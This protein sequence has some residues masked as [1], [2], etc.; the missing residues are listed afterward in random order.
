MGMRFLAKRTQHCEDHRASEPR[1]IVRGD[2]PKVGTMN[3]DAL[4]RRAQAFA[5]MQDQLQELDRAKATIA[6]LERNKGRCEDRIA[7]LVEDRDKYRREAGVFRTKLIELAT[8]MANISM[9]TQTAEQVRA[10]AMAIA[11]DEQSEQQA[12]AEIL[13]AAE[14]VKNLPQATV[15]V[16][17]YQGYSRNLPIARDLD[18]ANEA[19]V[20]EA[21]AN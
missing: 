12:E 21:L 18:Q 3:D 8:S 2:N 10:A 1:G 14:A 16:S 13:S 4:E 20:R 11:A 19:A 7:L 9:L 6:E 5:E 17:G 15:N